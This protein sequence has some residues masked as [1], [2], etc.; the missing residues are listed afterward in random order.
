MTRVA[1]KGLLGR[2]FRAVL[3]A[4]AIVLGIA[5]VSGTY[6]LTD[7]MQKAFDEVF[8]SSYRNTSVVISGKEL[9][10]GST[11]GNATVPAE[12]LEQVRAAP[13]VESASGSIL[14]FNSTSDTV[15]LVDEQGDKIGGGGGA[16]TFGFGIDPSQER[17]NPFTLEE[18]AWASGPRELVLDANAADKYGYAVGDSVA[19]AADGPART[20]T[21]VGIAKLGDLDSLGS[22]TITIF[23][24][25]TAQALLH[26]EGEFDAISVAARPGISDEQLVAALRPLVPASATVETATERADA[27][28]KDTAA[29]LAFIRYFL[30]AFG[31]IALFVGA[32]VIFNTISI[33]V[34]QRAREFATL[35]TLGAS[36]R[37]VLRSVVLETF[38]IG[39]LASIVGLFG[40]LAL[41]K[42]LNVLFVALGIELPETGL[43]FATRTVIVSLTVGIVVT[44]LAGLFP[45]IRATRVPPIA[46]VREGAVLP[47]PR[48][49]HRAT[50]IAVGLIALAVALMVDGLFVAEGAAAALLPLGVGTLLLF[51]GVALV[52]GRLVRPLAALVGLPARRLGGAAGQL[53]SDNSMRNPGRTASTAAA[54]MIGLAL[55]TFVATLGKGLSA[56]V[57]S[58]LDEQVQSDYVVTSVSGFDPFPA[59][60]SDALAADP[61]VTLAS[62]VRSDKARVFGSSVDVAGV[63]PEFPRA[64]RFDWVEGSDAVVRT[65]STDSVVLEKGYA[66][67]HH[68]RLDDLI[69]MQPPTGSQLTFSVQGIFEAPNGEPLLGDIMISRQA[70]DYNFPRPKNLFTFVDVQ[71]GAG[72]EATTALDGRLADFPDV[73][74]QTKAQWVDQRVS[75]IQT[76]LLTLYVLLALSVIVSLFGMVNTLVLAVFERTREVGMLRAVG[77]TQ[78]QVRTMIRQESIITAL[79]GAALGLSLGLFLAALMTRGLSSEGIGFHVPVPELVLF[80]LVAVVAGVL[81]AIIPARRAAR[82]N[83]LKALQYE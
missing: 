60:A 17:F 27:D 61:G 55:V 65:L 1:L 82:L 42:G 48:H 7:T 11:S 10:E 26:K 75:E 40:G 79:I 83:V 47:R 22:A 5:M 62:S 21:V 64:Y 28:A 4:L 59:E 66:E 73:D 57:E 23:D 36:R 54:L 46:A 38:V 63:G 29:D 24:L 80:T 78:R 81:A 12:L 35:R 51:V 20:Y 16:P 9:V 32:F 18:G 77:M 43:V 74:V 13:Q 15:T 8:A 58:S 50:W 44:L 34:A 52:S 71:G 14:D 39:L 53:A 25:P 37:Q 6:V 41:A 30:L 69:V 33:T 67:A 72:D 19:A 3:T 31:G 76:L 45:A 2:K 68:L 56:S 70:F 49:P